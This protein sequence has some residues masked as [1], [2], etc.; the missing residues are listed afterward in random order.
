[1]KRRTFIKRGSIG[2]SVLITGIAN[3]GDLWR[4]KE[5]RRLYGIPDSVRPRTALEHN[6]VRYSLARTDIPVAAWQNVVA[7]GFLAE[8]V[9]DHPAVAESFSRDPR[10]Y[11]RAVGLGDVELDP[12][13]IEVKIALA[14]GDREIRSAIERD[15]PLAYLRALEYRGVLNSADPSHIA[16][17][18]AEQIEAVRGRMGSGSGADAC[19]PPFTCILVL[20]VWIFVAVVQD[21][22]AA[23]TVLT[24]VSVFTYLLVSSRVVG[25]KM[26]IPETGSL[27]RAPSFRLAG[28]LGGE[29][30]QE[31][32]VEAFVDTTVERIATALEGLPL[33][34]KNQPMPGEELRR[35]VRSQM[36]RQMSGNAV[37][38]LLPGR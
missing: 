24:G 3:A 17:M 31:K 13:A 14:L 37:S 15:D 29:E 22:A 11:L 23:V 35:L 36:L 38:V 20:L 16:P 1:M 27:R 30:F 12:D 4:S 18:L 19:V 33:Y 32:A 2:L 10:R 9:F 26:M 25:T 7:L 28:V 5:R 21:V 8:D 6:L 34:M